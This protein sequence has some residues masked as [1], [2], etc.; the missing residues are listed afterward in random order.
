MSIEKPRGYQNAKITKI[1]SKDESAT[2]E[3]NG[4]A[5]IILEE[6]L[7]TQLIIDIEQQ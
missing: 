7:A 5:S 2:L 1:G 6:H 4:G 3:L